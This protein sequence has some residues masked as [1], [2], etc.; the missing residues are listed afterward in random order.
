MKEKIKW[1]KVG[2]TN[3]ITNVKFT[4]LVQ[5]LLEENMPLFFQWLCNILKINQIKAI[6]EKAQKILQ[7][8]YHTVYISL[9]HQNIKS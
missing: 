7:S 2:M 3:V 4:G 9:V 6:K 8:T 1:D 5:T